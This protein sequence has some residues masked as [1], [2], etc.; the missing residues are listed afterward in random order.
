[1]S[2]DFEKENKNLGI[3]NTSITAL[4][5]NIAKEDVSMT[6]EGNRPDFS[7][8][9]ARTFDSIKN[10]FLNNTN[11]LAAD[12]KPTFQGLLRIVT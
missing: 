9:I 8:T 11:E 10:Y 7:M 6:F 2:V 5:L 3:L 4:S 1:M 12:Q